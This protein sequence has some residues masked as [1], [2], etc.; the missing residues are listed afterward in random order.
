MQH[1]RKKD[2]QGKEK[3]RKR[4]KGKRDSSLTANQRDP[5]RAKKGQKQTKTHQEREREQKVLGAKA[6]Q[7]F[8]QPFADPQE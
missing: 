2:H 7:P 4:E 1:P 3:K 6:I 8:A 5:K